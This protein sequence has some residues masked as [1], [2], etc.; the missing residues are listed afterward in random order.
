MFT[1]PEVHL[2]KQFPKF[3]ERRDDTKVRVR[4]RV[5]VAVGVVIKVIV[6]W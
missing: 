4:V 3:R 6:Q 5:T 1:K 2:P